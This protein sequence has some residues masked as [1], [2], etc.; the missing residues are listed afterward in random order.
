MSNYGLQPTVRLGSRW[1]PAAEPERYVDSI[2]KL[3]MLPN[4]PSR[5]ILKGTKEHQ[6]K[7]ASS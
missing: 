2:S 3:G 1:A 6:P 5:R 7:G 4:E